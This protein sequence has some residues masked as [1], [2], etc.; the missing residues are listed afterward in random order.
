MADKK[1][2]SRMTSWMRPAGQQSA[3]RQSASQRPAPSGDA[4]PAAE[5]TPVAVAP[6]RTDPAL[7]KL[8][9]GY[10]KVIEL[11]DAIKRHQQEQEVRAVEVSSSLAQVAGT[12]DRIDEA[13]RKQADSLAIIAEEVRG[14]NLRA[15]QWEEALGEFPKMASAQREARVAV[16]TQLE[17]AG[18]RD[19]TLTESLESFREAV[20][21]LGDATTASSVAIK[22]LQLSALEQQQRTAGLIREQSRRF[23][24][25]F[26][27]TLI[28]A[29]VGIA[30]G[31]LSLLNRG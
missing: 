14:G 29:A 9:E 25:L 12:L 5:T 17:E 19:G 13:G 11:V 23:T 7:A 3:G 8:E 1:I 24:M 22:D 4:E 27:I 2:W 18:R 28:L 20:G 6:K 26:V 21:T 31:L 15:G 10:A 16:V 30:A